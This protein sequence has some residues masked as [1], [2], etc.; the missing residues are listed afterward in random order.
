MQ[1]TDE[2]REQIRATGESPVLTSAQKDDAF[3]DDY[4]LAAFR[5]GLQYY[6]AGRFA[7]AS[8]FMPVGSTILHHGV[9]FF[10]L[11]CLAVEDTAAQIRE[12]RNTYR[13]HHV[14]DLWSALKARYPNAGL[15]EFDSPVASL[16]TFEAIRFPERF[17]GHGAR[18]QVGFGEP[19]RQSGGDLKVPADRDFM[20]DV[21]PIDKLVVKLFEIADLNPRFFDYTL[22]HQLAEPFFT[23]RNETPL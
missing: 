5:F 3:A 21:R 16:S 8:A 14:Q 20:L 9:E 1:L 12:C 2:Q 10:L 23:L 17:V 7:V 19:G 15:G 18:L 4:V 22:K 13:G 6:G 11:G